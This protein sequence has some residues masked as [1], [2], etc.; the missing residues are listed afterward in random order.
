[1]WRAA[2]AAWREVKEINRIAK[3]TGVSP[4]YVRLNEENIGVD[5]YKIRCKTGAF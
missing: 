5:I 1:M 4:K 3:L 2:R